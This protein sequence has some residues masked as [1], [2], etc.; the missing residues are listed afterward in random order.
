LL[1]GNALLEKRVHIMFDHAIVRFRALTFHPV[2]V[3]IEA[4][5]IVA[6]VSA[7]G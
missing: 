2:F 7:T 6:L 5:I 3:T 4:G 1:L